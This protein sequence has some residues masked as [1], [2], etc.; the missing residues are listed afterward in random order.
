MHAVGCIRPGNGLLLFLEFDEMNRFAKVWDV[1]RYT[2]IAMIKQN[3]PEGTIDIR[4]YFQPE[5]H[6]ISSFL[7]TWPESSGVDGDQVFSRMVMQDA[8]EAVDAFMAATANGG[9]Q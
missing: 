2:Q 9:L 1:K 7:M 3:N 8:I 6:G 4:V 5:G